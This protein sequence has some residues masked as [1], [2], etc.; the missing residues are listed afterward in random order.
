MMP[1][2]P[3]TST[4]AG[5]S[6]AGHVRTLSAP[7]AGDAIAAAARDV[8]SS[9]CHAN[10]LVPARM[11]ERDRIE[12]H[13]NP[14]RPGYEILWR[15]VSADRTIRPE[16]STQLRRLPLLVEPE[17]LLAGELWCGHV[18]RCGCDDNGQVRFF[19][20]RQ[21]VDPVTG[22]HPGPHLGRP[23]L[24]PTT[25]APMSDLGP[26]EWTNEHAGDVAYRDGLPD[27]AALPAEA[28][29]ALVLA[30]LDAIRDARPRP[31]RAALLLA[32][33]QHVQ[34]VRAIIERHAPAVAGP[35]CDRQCAPWPCPDYRSATRGIVA[36]WAAP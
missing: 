20:C 36:G 28:A 12:I 18:H 1:T 10:G 32:I 30:R 31:P 22:R 21:H 7:W 2:M 29:H 35:L 26:A 11:L 19:T 6:A 3:A 34:G 5:T 14:N 16:A 24:D 27:V 33:G 4:I 9:W 17:G 25:A 15:E 8:L 23:S 13:P